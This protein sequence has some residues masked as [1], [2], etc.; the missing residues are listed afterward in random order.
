M[1]HESHVDGHLCSLKISQLIHCQFPRLT[2]DESEC[3]DLSTGM[4]R[5]VLVL[6]DVDHYAV[7]ENFKTIYESL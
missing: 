1:S 7:L 6:H 4:E 2:P 5:I 3:K